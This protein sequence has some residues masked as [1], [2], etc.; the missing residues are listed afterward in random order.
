MVVHKLSN[1][2]ALCLFAV[3]IV[4][5][6]SGC[7]KSSSINNSTNNPF[8][9][10]EAISFSQEHYAKSLRATY[11]KLAY[12][13]P[14]L[15]T[16]QAIQDA[17]TASEA[18]T[19]YEAEID[20]LIDSTLL[21]DRLQTYFRDQLGV[22]DDS[23]D[24]EDAYMRY[25]VNLGVFVILSGLPID[26]FFLADYA[27]DDNDL[28]VD[29]SYTNGPP[30][31]HMAGFITHEAY[32]MTYLNKQKFHMVREVLGIGLNSVAPYTDIDIYRWDPSNLAVSYR[33]IPE[34]SD[35]NC[36]PCHVV[37]NWV[38]LAFRGYNTKNMM[39]GVFPYN[40]N[41]DQSNDQFNS[42]DTPGTPGIN[43]E[44]RD[45]DDN[46]IA[47]TD[48]N[49]YVK[50]TDSGSAI[51]NPRELATA[52]VA[53]PE[54]ASAWTERFLTIMLDLDEGNTGTNKV[55]PEHFSANDTQIEFLA[56]WTDVFEAEG[57][58]AKELFRQFLKDAQYLVLV[59][60][61]DGGS[62]S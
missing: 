13:L 44:P 1:N 30:A 36:E 15:T 14:D 2:A 61:D 50:M 20:A 34:N 56:K 35:I 8:A 21:K 10:P 28:E 48:I 57:R 42:E 33:F 43:N 5:G 18:Q 32:A 24:P 62:E 19:L 55:V 9:N 45:S 40:E 52:I 60:G 4:L 46:V 23:D 17:A 31:D 29:A 54:F 25:P 38:R 49:D 12:Q 53:H 3:S 11:L 6:L 39:G 37:N 27:I 59:Y 51:T 7:T 22:W 16:L 47:E 26:E 58:V 41:Q